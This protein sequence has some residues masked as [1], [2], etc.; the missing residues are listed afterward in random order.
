MSIEK[1]SIKINAKCG[2]R[3]GEEGRALSL[4]HDIG[5]GEVRV[6]SGDSFESGGATCAAF[7]STVRFTDSG[8]SRLE[9]A[10]IGVFRR[11]GSGL[12]EKHL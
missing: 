2:K 1:Q 8:A 10:V 4:G 12:S 7:A 9:R 6:C 3:E 11:I 5:P